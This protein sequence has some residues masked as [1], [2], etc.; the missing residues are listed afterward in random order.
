MDPTRINT[1]PDVIWLSQARRV[2]FPTFKIPGDMYQPPP[3]RTQRILN[4]VGSFLAAFAAPLQHQGPLW[5]FQPP[6]DFV[7]ARPSISLADIKERRFNVI[8]RHQTWA[9]RK[10]AEDAKKGA[11]KGGSFLEKAGGPW[12]V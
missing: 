12:K 2:K 9:E 8:E 7:P 5:F 1:A 10:M 6:E 11:E 4:R 3:T